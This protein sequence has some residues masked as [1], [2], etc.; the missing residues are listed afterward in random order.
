[1]K[2]RFV[3]FLSFFFIL[4]LASTA[5]PAAGLVKGEGKQVY[6]VS[7]DGR[8][9]VFPNER[10][11]KTWYKNFDSV[12]KISNIELNALPFGGNITYRPGT[13]LLKITTDPKVYAVAATGTLRWVSTEDIAVRLYGPNWSKSVDNLPDEIFGSYHIGQPIL[14][15]T[16]FSPVDEQRLTTTIDVD[17]RLNSTATYTVP[18]LTLNFF[19]LGN[20][21]SLDLSQTRDWQNPSLDALRQYVANLNVLVADSLTRASRYHGYRDASAPASLSYRVIETKEYL[22]QAPMSNQFHDQADHF[23]ILR[24]V[25]ICRYVDQL[26]VKEVWMWMAH[27]TIESNMAMGQLSKKYWTAEEYGDVSNSFRENDLPTCQHTYTVYNYNYGRGLSE[28]LENHGHQLEAVFNFVDSDLFWKKFVGNWNGKWPKGVR[29]CG[30]VHVPPNGQSDYDWANQAQAES[31]CEDWKPDGG[32]QT[33]IVDCH[34]WTPNSP[35][36]SDGN[37]VSKDAASTWKIYWMQNMPGLNNGLTYKGK[38]LRN[39]WE[40]VGDFDAAVAQGRSFTQ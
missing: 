15:Y 10:T 11:F 39:W 29:R 37:D 21:G 4:P 36:C 1:M 9:Y 31:D 22:R 13:R 3:F 32:G 8:R 38:P 35:T 40:F 16:D 24:D 5:A 19:P 12:Q 7:T 28:A 2:L 14:N 25:D 33:K 20:N 17:R 18:V 30:W 6:Y 23:K 27:A 26:G 34:T